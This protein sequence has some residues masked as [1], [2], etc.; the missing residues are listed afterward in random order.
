VGAIVA[1]AAIYLYIVYPATKGPSAGREVEFEVLGDESAESLA[2]RL[3]GAGVVRQPLVLAIYVR[4][5]GGMD[6]I[7]SGTHLLSDDAS[8]RELLA[9]LRR[10]TWLPRRKVTIVEGFTVF[11]IAKRLQA[12]RVCSAKR[13]LEVA[14][15]PA[16]LKE[17]GLG[18]SVEGFLFPA[19]YE[20]LPNSHPASVIQRMKVE[21]DKRYESLRTKHATEV[22]ARAS[23]LGWT[24]REFVTLASM[25]EKEAV[26]DDER[27]II[28]SVF[29]NRLRDSNFRPRLLQCDPTAGYGC[30]VAE[31]PLA[32]CAGYTGKI[33]HELLADPDNAYNTYKHEG[34]PPGP[35]CN[36]GAKSL[37]AAMTPATTKYFYFVA[38]GAGRH[39]F[40][41]TYAGHTANI[42]Q[43]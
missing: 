5:T 10:S 38:K 31:P 30:L 19:T 35:I 39:A 1:M 32:S 25:I 4:A 15:E 3:E 41:E 37:E 27:S 29:L 43:P 24:M 11:D 17:H 12:N 23:E 7:A 2:R 28:A 13:F 22:A 20:F 42:R 34:L 21:F 8:P 33:T 18:G 9:L 26:V 40:S 14:R 6:A 16:V 36:P